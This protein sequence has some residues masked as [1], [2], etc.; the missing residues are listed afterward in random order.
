M[1]SALD[2]LIDAAH[3]LEACGCRD[4]GRA[5]LQW[6]PTHDGT[7]YWVSFVFTDGKGGT[8]RVEQCGKTL[9]AAARLLIDQEFDVEPQAA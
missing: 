3:Q 5:G 2:E 8:E 7:G 4:C 6:G 9:E 1:V